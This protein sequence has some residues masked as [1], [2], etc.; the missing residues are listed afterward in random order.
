LPFCFG[1]SWPS[2]SSPIYPRLFLCSV[3]VLLVKIPR[4]LDAHQQLMLSVRMLTSLDQKLCR[5]NIFCT[6]FFNNY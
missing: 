3:S 2:G 4:R 5:W 1:N 6:E